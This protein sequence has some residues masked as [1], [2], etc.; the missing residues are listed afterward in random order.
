MLK[1]R[2]RYTAATSKLSDHELF[3]SAVAL[4]D[5][6]SV[7]RIV[8]VAVKQKRS[9]TEI[10]HRLQLSLRGAYHVK[11]FT[12]NNFDLQQ[13][14]LD[15]GGPKLCYALSK[16]LNLPPTN[17]SPKRGFSLQIDEVAL[18]HRPRYDTERDAV[19]GFSRFDAASCEMYHPTEDRL[20]AMVDALQEGTLTR[21]TE[22]T[23]AAIAPYHREFYTPVPLMIS[24]TCKRETD[25]QQ[26]KWIKIIIETWKTSPHGESFYG[27]LWSIASD[28]DAV[29]R[30]ALHTICMSQT[31]SCDSKLYPLLGH[32][33]LMNMRCGQDELTADFDYK[34]K[35]KNFASLIRSV[36]GF[37][38]AG[39]HI[40][41][42]LLR[43]KLETLPGMDKTRLDALFNNKDHMNVNNAVSLHSSLYELSSRVDLE[44]CDP[45]D[46]PI[47]ILGRLCGYLTR[48]FII[49]TMT[50]SEQ[51]ESLS[52]AAHMFFLL[53]RANR[54]SFCPGQLY[55][56]IQS[57]IKNVYW[58]VAK[59][60]DRLEGLYGIY[61]LKD[62]SRNFDILQLAERASTTAESCR[63]FAEHP[64]WDRGHKR[65]RLQGAEGVDH[66][67]PKSWLGDVHV[68]NV[69][70]LTSHNSGRRLAVGL[71][72]LLRV[73]FEN[74]STLFDSDE[75]DLM[76]P[77]GSYVGLREADIDFTIEEVVNVMETSAPNLDPPPPLDP[78]NGI[79]QLEEL[80][81][82]PGNNDL[83]G[84]RKK[85]KAWLTLK[86]GD[87]EKYC[88]KAS[89]VRWLL[90]TEEG[91][92]STDRLARVQGLAKIR[93]YSRNP[94]TPTLADESI[95]GDV[96]LLNHLVATFIRIKDQVAL[97]ILRVSAIEN[98][99]K[100]LLS[101]IAKSEL[102]SD[103]ITLR[104]QILVLS[105]S[106]IDANPTTT[107]SKSVW[108]WDPNCFESFAVDGAVSKKSSIIDVPASFTR[109]V[110]GALVPHAAGRCTW[111]FETETLTALTSFLWDDIKSNVKHLPTRPKATLTFPYRDGK[112]E[113]MFISSEGSTAVQAAPREGFDRCYLCLT[114]VELKKMRDHV[115]GH[116]AASLNG[117]QQKL[118][119]PVSL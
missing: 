107:T 39:H 66:T 83:D 118:N 14:V 72:E 84:V 51:L 82:E 111:Q 29:R 67:N 33:P 115:G 2:D 19:V 28:G 47:V 48:P 100:T 36:T 50:L 79:E 63:I 90:C 17:L 112:D 35:F 16:A 31:L 8:S 81:P 92:K 97:A 26:T 75:I 109:I 64:E 71:F 91:L 42:I 102:S 11:S 69:S 104:G 73:P 99:K 70:L 85:D 87:K 12:A 89:A 13:L 18:D 41:S 22:A 103:K 34:H 108:I 78:D 4:D 44:H 54:T 88:H 113:M 57:M 37:L 30:R 9:I 65:L 106:K 117:I 46:I 116:L 7:G 101:C 86:E 74:P 58:S 61:R 105:E 21:A 43:A 27:P 6:S 98:E 40:S 55:Y 25:P 20:G 94:A 114:E 15:F 62:N 38:I 5:M 77:H 10:I 45:G 68:A 60:K 96:F 52:A 76:R 1:L 24:G 119:I 56:D 32:L 23:V 110:K 93:S 95:I 59:Q 49:P 3:V 53:F 80:L